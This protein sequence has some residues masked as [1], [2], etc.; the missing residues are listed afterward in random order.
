MTYVQVMVQLT[1]LYHEACRPDF[2]GKDHL[3]VYPLYDTIA[4]TREQTAGESVAPV[5][6][7]IKDFWYMVEVIGQPPR[8]AGSSADEAVKALCTINPDM[9]EEGW[10]VA[11]SSGVYN[12][13]ESNR[14]E[15]LAMSL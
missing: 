13:A 15:N 10:V 11:E 8:Y 3:P 2:K 1:Q 14:I 5:I 12:S 4:M 7:V 6:P 9:G